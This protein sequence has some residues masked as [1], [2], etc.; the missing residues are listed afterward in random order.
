GRTASHAMSAGREPTGRGGGL[1]GPD[2]SQPLPPAP[3]APPIPVAVTGLRGEWGPALDWPET[4]PASSGESTDYQPG[5][6]DYQSGGTDYLS[7]GTDYRTGG[8]D[9]RTDGT[10]YRTGGTDYPPLGYPD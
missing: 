9:Y 3:P 4:S 2:D 6:T 10:D 1:P 8:T 7:S 5:S